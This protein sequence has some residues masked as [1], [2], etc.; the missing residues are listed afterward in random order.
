M[1]S[2]GGLFVGKS[3]RE[4][5]SDIGRLQSVETDDYQIYNSSQVL[6]LNSGLYVGDLY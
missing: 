5:I 3:D 1:K 6:L 2:E 4:I